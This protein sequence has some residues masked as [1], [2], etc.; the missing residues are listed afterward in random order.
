ML[1]I[2]EFSEAD[3]Y[4]LAEYLPW[5]L[6]CAPGLVEHK[7]GA[8]QKTYRFRG[9]D[10]E[11]STK[12]DLIGVSGAF[13]NAMRRLSDGWAIFIEAQRNPVG[14]Y[15]KSSWPNEA[16]KVI[17]DERKKLFSDRENNFANDY[18]LTF[19]YRP[20]QKIETKGASWFLTKNH[21]DTKETES[22]KVK[23]FQ[24]ALAEVTGLLTGLFS[25][26][27]PLD[28]DETLTY[29]HSTVSSKRHQ[30]KTPD[31]PMYL[32][33]ILCDESVEHG[34]GLKV[35]HNVVKT[36]TIKGFPMESFPGILDELNDLDFS[37]RW[38]TRFLCMGHEVAKVHLSKIKRIW[39]SGRKKLMTV[40]KEVASQSESGLSETTAMN[41]SA[42]TDE[43][44]QLLDQGLVS[45]G[46]FTATVT[47]WDE[48][49]KN[50]DDKIQKVASVINR[51]G[52]ACQIESINALDSW[53]S[54]IPGIIY[55]NVRKPIIHTLNLAHMAPLS[56]IWAGN[57]GNSHLKGPAHFM[58]KCRGNTPF[59][60]SS[61][62]GDVGHTLIFGPTGTGKSTLLSFMAAQWLR[63]EDAQV[64]I[65]DKGSSSRV[66]T[67]AVSGSFYN[68]GKESE[69]F[70]FQPFK[71][72]HCES[73]QIWANEWL[74]EL[75][76]DQGVAINAELRSEVWQVL[77]NLCGQAPC[78]RTIS[79]FRS[80][81]QSSEVREAL[82]PFSLGG[83]YGYLFD[84]AH[85]TDDNNFWQVF[86]TA[87][88]FDQKNAI[89]PALSYLFHRL[90]QRFD[91]RPTLLILD[92]AWLFLEDSMFAKKIKQ[93]LKELRKFRVYV[94]FATQSLADAME[95]PIVI[96]LKE[97][98]PT[99]IFLPNTNAKDVTSAKFYQAMGINNRQIE[100]IAQAIPKKEYYVSSP[101]GNRLFDLAL[102]SISLALC[103]SSSVDDQKIVARIK[104][105]QFGK[106]FLENYLKIKGGAGNEGIYM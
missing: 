82:K 25:Y 10:L 6:F 27:E 9:P 106:G 88:L 64:F 43:A 59:K 61:N 46:H 80:L 35:G 86:E 15:P 58:A 71:D 84:G 62:V 63:Y 55:A 14:D 23:S 72:I 33:H 17:D 44:L 11:S 32:D 51:L 2:K 102:G 70:C 39:F 65:F 100:I 22:V 76:A 104:K 97:S 103:A 98:C 34:L 68:I 37:F 8:L 89:K 12:R 20:G 60:F 91:G 101:L 41:K 66:I 83:P 78:S 74:L 1:S 50:A 87:D 81:V 38:A 57:D 19:V 40:L 5:S 31:I 96:A 56:A 95:S 48:Y 67:E 18:F 7:D 47:V 54:S 4:S 29:L 21:G 13:N 99:K 105:D 52:F 24:K 94:I 53:L 75:L 73:E 49:E 42:D 90:S 28:D 85:E 30:I 36:L 77:L 16:S 45:F 93:W 79:V 69:D 92:E 26:F 3:P